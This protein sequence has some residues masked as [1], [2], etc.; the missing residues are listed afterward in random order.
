ML[1]TLKP[2]KTEGIKY[3]QGRYLFSIVLVMFILLSGFPRYCYEVTAFF[4]L[5]WY[6][7]T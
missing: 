6:A 5:T 3:T 2:M 1:A 4:I 7:T